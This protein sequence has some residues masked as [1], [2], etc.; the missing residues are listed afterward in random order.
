MYSG[1]GGYVPGS[2]GSQG[3]PGSRGGPGVSASLRPVTIRQIIEASQ[4]HGDA[5]FVIDGSVPTQLTFVA[6]VVNAVAGA[7]N[8]NFRVIDG[9][10]S[11]EV[12]Q[13]L[14][15]KEEGDE[16]VA[17][18]P[19]MCWVRI[20]GNLKSFNGKKHV[21]AARI[22][23][24]TDY[25]EIFFHQLE[26]L[27]AHLFFTKGS[28]GEN[29][30]PTSNAAGGVPSAYTSG[31]AIGGGVDEYAGHT[32][33]AKRMLIWIKSNTT[34]DDGVIMT[35]IARGVKDSGASAREISEAIDFLQDN[36]LIYATIDDDHYIA[37]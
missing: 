3:S 6:Q 32:P 21:T 29:N 14:E 9:T 37:A 25:N 12:R 34:S 35:D 24:V 23:R 10:G 33:L 15:S 5:E 26:A 36:G 20:L 18:F 30:Q 31:G 8:I 16:L 22:F 4:E 7:T 1:G 19:D 11:M 17:S 27:Q 2:Q 28:L 13:W